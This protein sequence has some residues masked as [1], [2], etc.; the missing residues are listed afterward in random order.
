MAK[1]RF[2]KTAD[3]QSFQKKLN[4]LHHSS[5]KTKPSW[6]KQNKTSYQQAKAQPSPNSQNHAHARKTATGA[7]SHSKS[8]VAPVCS[9]TS[10]AHRWKHASKS[11]LWKNPL[12]TYK[13][14]CSQGKMTRS[15][16]S[17]SSKNMSNRARCFSSGKAQYGHN[18]GTVQ[19]NRAP[20]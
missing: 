1:K 4:M 2:R 9:L 10:H 14:S 6:Q 13:C 7:V 20:K 11:P 12:Q 15:Y 17:P 19:K 16:P 5:P 3:H 18:T 8:S